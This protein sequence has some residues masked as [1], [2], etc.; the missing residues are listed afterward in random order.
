MSV[1]IPLL[2]SVLAV[3]LLSF[4][5]VASLAFGQKRIQSFLLV[6]VAFASGSLLAVAFLHMAPEAVEE[7]GGQAFTFLLGGILV[8]FI[9][10][11][12]IHWHHCGKEECDVRPVGYLTLLSDGLHNFIDGVI[13]SAA[14]LTGLEVGVITTLAIAL[15][16]IP[17][18]FGDFSV[19]LHSGF[20][21]RKA[22]TYNFIS[23]STA[24]L[25]ALVGYNFLG[26]VESRIP[27]VVAFAAGGF[28]YIAT[29]DLMPELHHEKNRLKLLQQVVA[30]LAGVGLIYLA[31]QFVPAT[32]I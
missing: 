17:Q 20:T 8:F 11:K 22:L 28:I 24:I 14:Y 1:L 27:F 13:I 23:A 4:V 18:E 5:G 12:F 25:G 26:A 31:F 3:S 32:H 29:A 9:F 19:L 15:H 16:E 6:F 10:E 7:L 2:L 30:L 21:V